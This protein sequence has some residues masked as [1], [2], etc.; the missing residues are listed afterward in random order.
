LSRRLLKIRIGLKQK[1]L[2]LGLL[3]LLC[4]QPC[5]RSGNLAT[6]GL[7]CLRTLGVLIGLRVSG[8]GCADLGFRRTFNIHRWRAE[9]C[10]FQ[11]EAVGG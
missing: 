11:G 1:R 8:F 10:D 4:R 9:R 6:S 7:L 2:L 5:A 3:R